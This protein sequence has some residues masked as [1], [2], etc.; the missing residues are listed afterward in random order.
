VKHLSRIRPGGVVAF[1]AL[2]V[3]M[4]GIAVADN[5]GKVK[6]KKINV[7]SGAIASN[8]LKNGGVKEQDLAQSVQDQLGGGPAPGPGP[9]PTNA[10][11]SIA[12]NVDAPTDNSVIYAGNGFNLR[13]SA[14]AANSCSLFVD[15]K[16]DNL[17]FAQTGQSP[18]DNDNENG[19]FLDNFDIADPD[20]SLLSPAG[21]GGGQDQTVNTLVVVPLTGARTTVNYHVNTY[22][23]QGFDCRIN[24]TAQVG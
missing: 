7:K 22:S 1:I 17:T 18:V 16:E 6:G 12:Y 13:A 19:V 24:G 23:P 9:A 11:T 14:P 4:S 5:D 3:A 21:E 8:E 10:N 2:F 15:A 20:A